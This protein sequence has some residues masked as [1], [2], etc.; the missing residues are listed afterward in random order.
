MARTQPAL[1]NA[2]ALAGAKEQAWAPAS[3]VHLRAV[4][5]LCGH[6]APPLETARVLEL[7]CGRG[8]H[9]QAFALAYPGAQVVGVDIRP[10]ELSAAENEAVALG[11]RNLQFLPMLYV[12]VDET[13][14]QFD[15]IIVRDEYSWAPDLMREALLRICARNLAPGGVVHFGFH[16]YPGGRI[17]D[18]VRDAIQLHAHDAASMDEIRSAAGAMLQLMGSQ[19]TFD[20]IYTEDVKRVAQ[21]LS[22]HPE[23]YISADFLQRANNPSYLIDIVSKA[24]E[25]GLVYLSDALPFTE[26]AKHYG[27]PTQLQMGLVA[28]GKV[29]PVRQQYLDFALNRAFRQSLFT[30]QPETEPSSAGA[31]F[32]RLKTL[33][34]A[35]ALKRR[36]SPAQ[37]AR[38]IAVQYVLPGGK[39]H[40]YEDERMVAVLDV[41]GCIWP[42]TLSFQE[43]VAATRYIEPGLDQPAQELAVQS[44]LEQLMAE[45]VL[46]ATLDSGP[47]DSTDSSCIH[48][49]GEL[50]SF[51]AGGDNEKR[52]IL[53]NLWG[54]PQ[55]VSAGGSFK[56]TAEL[57]E[58]LA[59]GDASILEK[60]PDL[61]RGVEYLRWS[62]L[63]KGSDEAWLQYYGLVLAQSG[64]ALGEK[65]LLLPAYIAHYMRLAGAGARHKPVSKGLNESQPSAQMLR[66]LGNLWDQRAFDK[67]GPAAEAFTRRFP[68]RAEGWHTLALMQSELGQA[69]DAMRNFLRAISIMPG[70]PNP[71][72]GMVMGQTHARGSAM[73]RILLGL[74]TWLKPGYLPAY[75]NLGNYYHDNEQP[76]SAERC[77]DQVL[78]LEPANVV[79]LKNKSVYLSERGH[80]EQALALLEKVVH[81]N[82]D[83]L[84]TGSNYLY[85]L[86][87]SE[88]VTPQAL[89]EAHR[90]Y[91][92]QVARYV[93]KSGVKFKHNNVRDPERPLNIGFVSGDLR[94]HAVSRFIEPVWQE[95]DR[96]VFRIFAYSV[97]NE[98]DTVTDA[99][100]SL[101]SKW[102][103][104]ASL[105]YERLAKQIHDD[106]IDILFDLSGHTG[107][108]RLPA[109]G[110]K[111]APIQMTWIGYPGTSGLQ[112]MDYYIFN[113]Y[114]APEGVLEWQ[115]TERLLRMPATVTFDPA[116]HAPDVNELPA[117]KNGFFTFG[118]FNRMNKVNP[119][120]VEA[121]AKILQGVP[122]SRLV[123]GHADGAQEAVMRALLNE[124]G[125]E[126]DR[127]S[128]HPRLALTQYASLHH[129][130]D[131]LLD[132]FP[133]NGGTTTCYGLWMGVPTLTLAGATVPARTGAAVMGLMGLQDFIACDV[134]DY[135]EKAVRLS[136]DL[137]RLQQIRQ[138]AREWFTAE[139]SHWH[140]KSV[141]DSLQRA[142]RQAW[143]LW[144]ADKAAQTFTV[145]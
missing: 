89:Y 113:D 40:E 86:S 144:C 17:L 119:R 61:F 80:T 126:S 9:I 52:H 109:F 138:S 118:S 131:M 63:L 56:R 4:A 21:R 120:V 134:D 100:R 36:Y 140:S 116:V 127:L 94:N 37:A 75:I 129:D 102:T 68:G 98:T 82:P 20:P 30:R 121:W 124:Q 51:E 81:K 60:R 90:R 110:F 18:V 22:S 97:C 139:G 142:M 123:I 54:E 85:N 74:L 92:M 42:Y 133:Y 93:K 15:Y 115:F 11:I 55:Q 104:A 50:A 87:L 122:K 106:E 47:Y 2:D 27:H 91:G 108:N 88:S 31:D 65:M 112:T 14:G 111:P 69:E 23:Y 73:R 79:A 72:M 62:G 41:L 8:R 45:R 125:I 13:L 64:I 34:F 19:N 6:Q 12:D 25:Q 99:L 70:D 76:V 48:F 1:K 101:T 145:Q 77:V 96:S 132:T 29:W 10:D 53:F 141:A 78:R 38:T 39:Q 105:S 32:S 143:R 103:P 67:L 5:H 95:M 57:F 43:I 130:I 128:F 46:C 16:T 28:M 35:C 66:E 83:D 44:I 26:Q 7:G 59:R 137:A 3:P 71:Y 117:K 136:A 33:A 107:H 135:L 49:I 24:Q 58:Q 114:L 84:S